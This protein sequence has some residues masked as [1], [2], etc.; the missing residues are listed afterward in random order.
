MVKRELKFKDLSE[1]EIFKHNGR[2][3]KKVRPH[4]LLWA[5]KK[6]ATEVNTGDEDFFVDDSTL[7]S[8]DSE[9]P[10]V[11]EAPEMEQVFEQGQL[12][13]EDPLGV[14]KTPEKSDLTFDYGSSEE[15]S[16]KGCDEDCDEGCGSCD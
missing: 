6:N 4:G 8:V 15:D 16:E 10:Q 9:L 12:E 7:V 2:W 3:L 11:D 5:P 13:C 1:G 14:E